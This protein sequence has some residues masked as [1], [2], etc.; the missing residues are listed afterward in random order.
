MSSEI[1]CQ[2]DAM[3]TRAQTRHLCSRSSG[4]ISTAFW[5]SSTWKLARPSD[6]FA[7]CDMTIAGAQRCP[8]WFFIASPYIQRVLPIGSDYISKSTQSSEDSSGSWSLCTLGPCH[9]NQTPRH[10]KEK[11]WA[12]HILSQ[13]A[14]PC[15]KATPY[16]KTKAVKRETVL[17]SFT[18]LN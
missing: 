9:C 4:S 6:S 8:K 17:R 2:P 5:P 7:H 1:L 18:I 16:S 12:T 13:Q 10:G 11:K 15:P 3:L 14:Q